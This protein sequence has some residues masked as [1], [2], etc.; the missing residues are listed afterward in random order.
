MSSITNVG[1]W[2]SEE[3]SLYTTFCICCYYLL[4]KQ[5]GLS[6]VFRLGENSWKLT[7]WEPFSHQLWEGPSNICWMNKWML[8]NCSWSALLSFSSSLYCCGRRI[9]SIVLTL[10]PSLYMLFVVWF[11]CFS[12]PEVEWTSSSIGS[13]LAFWL[14]LANKILW[15]CQC[16]SSGPR[17]P[18]ALF[19]SILY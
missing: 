3:L 2:V 8:S 16:A 10:H 19:A 6:C 18:E 1:H 7:S 15:E 14:V 5:L 13:G 17:S 11:S 9:A 4:L 12:Y